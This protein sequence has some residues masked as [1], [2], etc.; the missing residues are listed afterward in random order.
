MANGE[1]PWDPFGRKKVGPIGII[2]LIAYLILLALFLLYSLVALWPT[3]AVSVNFLG[4]GAYAQASS[5]DRVR[6]AES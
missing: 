2:L 3:A 4:S 5:G 1:K 6:E